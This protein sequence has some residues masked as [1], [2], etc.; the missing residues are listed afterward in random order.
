MIAHSAPLDVHRHKFNSLWNALT[1]LLSERKTCRREPAAH[2]SSFGWANGYGA[3]S[4]CL[5]CTRFRRHQVRCFMEQEVGHGET[6]V[7]ARVQA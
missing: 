2:L 5:S 6:E 7:H 3:S 4:R 1:G